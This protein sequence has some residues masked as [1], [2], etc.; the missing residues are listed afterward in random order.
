M[1]A[2]ARLISTHDTAEQ[3]SIKPALPDAPMIT[4]MEELLAAL[5]ARRDQL[6]LTHECIDAVAGWASGYAG[7]LLAPSPA[8]NMGWMSLGICLGSLGVGLLLVENP[9]QVRLVQR[10]WIK[11]E[12]PRNAAPAAGKGRRHAKEACSGV[13][14]SK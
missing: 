10:R 9:E 7:K 1:P 6:E 2:V 13:A 11:R 5:R 14:T 12:R 8:K 3:Q 4:S